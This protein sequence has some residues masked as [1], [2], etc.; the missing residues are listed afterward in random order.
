[1]SAPGNVRPIAVH[2]GL[3]DGINTQVSGDGLKEGMTIVVGDAT[4]DDVAGNNSNP[5]VP[6]FGKKKS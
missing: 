3:S 5:F 6:Q 1:P 2:V 4:P